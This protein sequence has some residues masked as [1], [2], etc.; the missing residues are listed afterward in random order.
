M[1]FFFIHIK[2]NFHPPCKV[3]EGWELRS[4]V[5]KIIDATLGLMKVPGNVDIN[6]VQS[7]CL[8]LPQSGLPVVG[9]DPA[10]FDRKLGN[11]L[12]WHLPEVMQAARQNFDFFS[13]KF[14]FLSNCCEALRNAPG[15]EV[16]IEGGVPTPH[17]SQTRNQEK[18]ARMEKPHFHNY[19]ALN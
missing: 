5:P 13:I 7:S 19:D 16:F 15:G 2:W 14:K 1:D 8:V 10:M 4:P 17:S 6:S 9:V 18:E 11:I 12:M 3:K